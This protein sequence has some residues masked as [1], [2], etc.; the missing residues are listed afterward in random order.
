MSAARLRVFGRCAK[1]PTTLNKA[2]GQLLV[3]S[4]RANKRTQRLVLTHGLLRLELRL[5]PLLPLV[6]AGQ[7][8]L[9]CTAQEN[10]AAVAEV[11]DTRIILRLLR[12]A[13]TL[14]LLVLTV[15]VLA[16]QLLT[17]EVLISAILA[18]STVAAVHEQIMLLGLGEVTQVTVAV[19]AGMGVIAALPHNLGA[20]VALVDIQVMAAL[21]ALMLVPVVGVL[22]AVQVGVVADLILVLALLPVVA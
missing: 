4:L 17:A 12:A 2:Y 20:V 13:L 15:T 5:F 1:Q 21:A 6:A 7:V 22:A 18:L 8:E 19:M 11:L 16:I 3:I 10:K 14:S 9:P